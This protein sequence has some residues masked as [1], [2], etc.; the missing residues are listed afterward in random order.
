MP[1]SRPGVVAGLLLAALALGTRTA[2]GQTGTIVGQVELRREVAAVARR[3][4][5]RG[6]GMPPAR[7]APARRRSVVYLQVAPREAFEG[8][9]AGPVTM[10]QRGEAFVPRVVAVIAGTEV[11]FSNSDETY[12]NVFSLSPVRPFDLGRYAA[13]RSRS[14]RFDQPGIVRVF[15]DIH[16]HMSAFILV[17]GHRF[18][19]ITDDDGRYRLDGVP[20]GTYDVVAWHEAFESRTRQVEVPAGADRVELNF[21]LGQ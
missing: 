13:G 7:A 2:M 6:Q 12:H 3:P 10:D 17:F 1:V 20:P 15:C 5:I 11:E 14:V 9:G 16:S 18:F 19:T 21:A 8:G 4:D